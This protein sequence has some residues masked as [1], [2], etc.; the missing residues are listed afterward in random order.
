MEWRLTDRRGRWRKP[1]YILQEIGRAKQTF[2]TMF[3]RHKNEYLIRNIGV[4]LVY[5]EGDRTYAARASRELD[6]LVDGF[7]KALT[8][9]HAFDDTHDGDLGTAEDIVNSLTDAVESGEY[10]RM[11]PVDMAQSLT[12]L[13]S[14]LP[15]YPPKC[16]VKARKR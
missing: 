5:G 9:Y 15:Y 8:Y 11:R 4:R 13:A 14:I 1:H 10:L 6:D 12:D 16:R 2:H 7:K 3:H